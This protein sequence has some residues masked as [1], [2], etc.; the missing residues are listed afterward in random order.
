MN[1]NVKAK[2]L[3]T[4]F[5]LI[6]MVL[7]TVTNSDA[8]RRRSYNPDKTRQQAIEI[9]R[10]GSEELCNLAGIAP[11]PKDSINPELL[12]KLEKD[13]E[14]ESLTTEIGDKGEDLSE[15]EKDDDVTISMEEFNT[16]WLSFLEA[17][18]EQSYT[19]AGVKKQELMDVIMDWLGTPYRFGGTTRQRIDCS[20]FTQK[21]FLIVSDIMI[22]R[23]A[24]E[25]VHI[26]KKVK[27]SELEFGDLI[28]FHTYSRRFASHVGIYLGD[29]LFAHASSRHGVTFASLKS[30]YYKKRF[31]G[32]RR[33][34]AQDMVKYSVY[35]NGNDH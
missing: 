2:A 25:Q 4:F 5:L 23:T 3:I 14:D 12:K 28:F 19:S 32:G 24:R 34:T 20:A 1:P 35:K 7:L 26:G 9:I 17:E 29:D 33:L 30:T 18:E 15:L 10:T 16:L 31:I 11:L 21:M 13:S 22:P 8:R 6:T 27:K